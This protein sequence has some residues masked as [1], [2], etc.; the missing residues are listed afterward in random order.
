MKTLGHTT[1]EIADVR[2][3]AKYRELVGNLQVEGLSDEKV[4]INLERA[5]LRFQRGRRN[6]EFGCGAGHSRDLSFAFSQRSLDDRFLLQDEFLIERF[7]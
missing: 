4:L 6:S 7:T 2:E 3:F 1:D 5:N